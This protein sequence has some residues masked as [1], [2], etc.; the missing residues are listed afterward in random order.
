MVPC[1]WLASFPSMLFGLHCNPGKDEAVPEIVL[2]NVILRPTA[3][4]L[5]NFQSKRADILHVHHMYV[6]ARSCY[7]SRIVHILAYLMYIRRIKRGV[8][9]MACPSQ[10]IS[11]NQSNCLVISCTVTLNRHFTCSHDLLLKSTTWVHEFLIFWDMM[12]V[13]LVS[14]EH[15]VT[16]RLHYLPWWRMFT[17]NYMPNNLRIHVATILFLSL[18]VNQSS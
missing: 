7:A 9:Q 4:P 12:L 11:V 6:C 18:T 16:W 5:N 8:H 3:V 15:S 10:N 2:A 14:W 13:C 17:S 1:D